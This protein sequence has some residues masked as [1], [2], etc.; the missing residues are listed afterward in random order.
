MRED[1][2]AKLDRFGGRI[3][4]LLG[5][6]LRLQHLTAAGAEAAIRKPLDVFNERHAAEARIAIEDALV[7]AI[8]D[9]VRSGQLTLSRSGGVGQTNGTDETAQIEAPFLQLVMTRLWEASLSG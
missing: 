8:I 4:N 9:Q 1:G 2:L 7:D 3:P 5:N 6:T